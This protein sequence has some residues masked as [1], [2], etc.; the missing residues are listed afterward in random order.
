MD[1]REAEGAVVVNLV[2]VVGEVVEWVVHL[3]EV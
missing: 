2:A 3:R 1:Q